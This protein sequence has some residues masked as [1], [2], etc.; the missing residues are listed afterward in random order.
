MWHEI[1]TYPG[2]ER[3]APGRRGVVEQGMRTKQEVVGSIERGVS[4]GP[5]GDIYDLER[6]REGAHG[7]IMKYELNAMP[8]QRA[9]DPV[10]PGVA[11]PDGSLK[12]SGSSKDAGFLS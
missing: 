6:G 8:N 10:S 3:L 1:Q 9:A 12:E 5:A 4:G 2:W 7:R 11:T